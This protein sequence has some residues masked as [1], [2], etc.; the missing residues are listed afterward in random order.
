M[1]KTAQETYAGIQNLSFEY[2][3]TKN[4]MLDQ[5]FDDVISWVMEWLVSCTKLSEGRDLECA[6]DLARAMCE[7]QSQD[8]R[9]PITLCHSE[10][11]IETCLLQ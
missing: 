7:L 5:T 11:Y 8:Y 3:H 9:K 2:A 4:F 10:L 6:H 1:L